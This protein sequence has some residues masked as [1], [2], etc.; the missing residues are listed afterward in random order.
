M[1][2]AFTLDEKQH[3][4]KLKIL[5]VDDEE[6]LLYSLDSFLKF[7]LSDY[8]LH[9]TLAR[10]G[11]EA[12]QILQKQSFD[13]ILMDVLMPQ[14]SGIEALGEI[15]KL[16]PQIFI[17][18]MTA[19][20]NLQ[21]AVEAIKLGAYDYIEKPINPKS[22][23]EIVKKALE[24]QEM[25]C[26]LVISQPI[27]DEK[28]ESN[29]IG[30]SEKMIEI[31][32]LINKLS[33]VDNPVL[34]QGEK[35]TGKELIAQAIHQNSPRKHGEFVTL[36]CSTTPSHLIE[37]EL[38][39]YEEEV[40]PNET[41]RKIGLLQMAN[42][43][44]LFLSEIDELSLDLQTKIL[45]V[46]NHKKFTPVG[47]HREITTKARII[48]TTQYDL[49]AKIREK[50]FRDDL[51]YCLNIMPIFM[52]PLRERKNDIDRL[53]PFLIKRKNPPVR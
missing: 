22:L 36:N 53:I 1:E 52:P 28:I 27:F 6:E 33:Q 4:Q 5:L 34:I 26:Q 14:V 11:K 19:H 25:V 47:G 42:K 2:E 40:S 9:I 29:V 20:G 23:A 10:D 48:A 30:S 17:V 12:I 45:N 8:Q 46:L 3:S 15:K 44:V 13:L 16:N 18:I 31:F 32:S 39:G 38:F 51:F 35:G 43:G 21:D 50:S 7:H 41:E 37:R 49:E 24:T